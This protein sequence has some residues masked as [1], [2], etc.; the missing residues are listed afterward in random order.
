MKKVVICLELYLTG[1]LWLLHC[2]ETE[3]GIGKTWRQKAL[4]IIQA[5]DNCDLD[6]SNSGR[7]E[8]YLHSGSV[9]KVES[10]GLLTD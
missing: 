6:Q 4:V 2:K 9:V 3:G 10:I 7:G 5:R 1:S 8:N